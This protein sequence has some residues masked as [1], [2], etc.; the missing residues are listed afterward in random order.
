M[1]RSKAMFITT[2]VMALLAAVIYFVWRYGRLRLLRRRHL[3]V[4]EP[5]G[6]GDPPERRAARMK[7][8][9]FCGAEARRSIAPA[10]GHPMGTYI[11]TIRC[12]NPHCGAE[13]HTLY[14][15]PPWTKDPV[16]QARLEIERRWNRRCGNG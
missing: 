1:S 10:K 2:M 3:P 14:P 15:A 12:G 4:D 16:R 13:M 9:P 8:C 5:A 6:S 7:A 11:A